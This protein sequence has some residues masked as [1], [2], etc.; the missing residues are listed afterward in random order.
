MVQCNLW[1]K[2]HYHDSNGTRKIR[3]CFSERDTPTSSLSYTGKDLHYALLDK[4][5][6]TLMRGEKG[7]SYPSLPGSKE[8]SV[9]EIYDADMQ[10]FVALSSAELWNADIAPKFGRLLRCIVHIDLARVVKTSA[11]LQSTEEKRQ[12]PLAIMGRYYDYDPNGMDYCGKRIVVKEI[13]NNLSE[14]GTGLNVWDGSVLLAKYVESYPDTVRGKRVLELGAGPGFVGIAAG[15]VGAAE[16]VLTDL[17][18]TIPLMKD[19]V[20]RN[21]DAVQ[22]S[23]C[24]RMECRVLDWYKPPSDLAEFAF[25]ARRISCCDGTSIIASQPDVILVADC[26]WLE[27]L[28]SP[29]LH[30]ISIISRQCEAAPLVIISYQRRGRSTHDALMS[31]LRLGFE[32]VQEVDDACFQ[33]PDVMSILECR[34]KGKSVK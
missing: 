2:D 31:G 28:V 8:S 27:E 23:G 26:V 3:I 15:I 6:E 16:V 10:R 24:H 5:N 20:E 12:R 14:D 25:L 30:A 29:L 9:V 13:C 11:D 1:D 18:Y 34:I 19:N 33:K 21:L 32:I 7:Q 22:S 4:V 17:E